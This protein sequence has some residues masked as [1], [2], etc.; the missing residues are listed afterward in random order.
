MSGFAEWEFSKT[1]STEKSEATLHQVSAANAAAT[2]PNCASAVEPDTP[3]NT[4]SRARTPHTGTQ[5]CTSASA[6]AST[7]A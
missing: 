3:I 6:S 1:V 7:K 2:N 4:G 5:P